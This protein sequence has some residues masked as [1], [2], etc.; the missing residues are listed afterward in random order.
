MQGLMMDRP[1]LTT[2][3]LKH[4]VR[5]YHS[6]EIV[7]RT[8]EGPIH[9]YNIG[10]AAL[11]IAKLANALIKIGVKPG[12]KVGVIGWNTYRQFEMYYAVGGIGAVL[13]TINPRLG[14][15]NAGYVINHAED[16]YMFFDATFLPLVEALSP[17]LK[18][19]KEY[20]VLTDEAH[21]PETKLP[22]RLYEDL[23]ARESEFFEWPEFDDSTAVS[24]CYT[25]GTTG[26]PKGVLYS[27]RAIVL[28]TFAS[29]LPSAITAKEGDVIL[30]VVPMFHVN[31]WNLPYSCLMNGAK[32]VFPGPRLD[33]EGLYVMLEGEKVNFAF[34]VP[35]VWL[36]LLQ[37][38]AETGNTL[39][40]LEIAF[41]GGSALTESLVRGF[42]E[43]GVEIQQGWGMT[44]MSPL[45]TVNKLPPY[46]SKLSED[47][48]IKLQLKQGRAVPFVDMRIVSDTGESL[49]HDGITD[50][51][52]QVRGPWIIKEYYKEEKPTL[53]ADGW[54]DTGDVATIDKEGFLQIT[55]RS[56][57]VIK[58]GGEWIS[59]IEIE[60]A[61]LLHPDVGN[62]AVIGV[63]HPKW[64]ERPL[65]IVQPK[66]G[67]TPS[68]EDISAFVN[69]RLPKIAWPDAIEFVE[70]IP[71]GATGK[72]LKTEL[73]RMFADYKL[74]G[75]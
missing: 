18:T 45:G 38:L 41:S 70:E 69:A 28:Q 16:S 47:D 31:A 27:H 29:G 19:V 7:T 42:S 57:D 34:G 74:P 53:T 35:T 13:H 11:R 39:N 73:R 32:Q 61:A 36:G 14:P 52:L 51:N 26:N 59:S 50:G 48:R 24:M 62:A 55:D 5:T 71:L 44:E 64:D 67:I 22:I 68:A 56:K 23:I 4:A 15:E 20:V 58:S 9:R 17:H 10:A 72:V 25:S 60:N 30:P 63:Y 49:P 8:V 43:H 21:R 12:D 3:I 2:E 40:H 37:Y 65:L 66:Q 54:F 6:T 75:T 46:A 33:G 1:L